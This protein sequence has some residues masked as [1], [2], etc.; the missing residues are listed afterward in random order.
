MLVDVVVLLVKA[1]GV[2]FIFRLFKTDAADDV[3]VVEFNVGGMVAIACT[4]VVVAG[5]LGTLL[6][7]VGIFNSS[8]E[9]VV[10]AFVKT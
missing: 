8:S 4:A 2:L 1:N 6:L 5:T 7:L 9:D 3:V 10:E